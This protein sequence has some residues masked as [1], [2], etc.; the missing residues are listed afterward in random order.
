ME[1]KQEVETKGQVREFL[2]SIKLGKYFDKFIENGVDDL[3]TILDL[4]ANNISELGIPMGHR[5]K[6]L[7]NINKYKSQK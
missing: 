1:E 2:N 7:K 5:L 3:E 6:M 4:N